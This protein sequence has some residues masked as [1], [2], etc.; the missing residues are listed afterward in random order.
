MRFLLGFVI[1]FA[2]AQVT[3]SSLAGVVDYDL[4]IAETRMAPAGKDVRVLTINGGIPGPTLRF[5]E[6]DIAR[7]V[8]RNSLRHEQT[9]IH[10]HGLL[11]PNAMD[12]VPYLTTPP[13]E[14]GTEMVFEFP[15]KHAGTYW[16]HS[17]TGLQEQSGVYG[18]IVVEPKGGEPIA[19]D[20]DVVVVLSDWTNERPK[21][22]M[23]T[24]MRGSDWYSIEK[25]NAQSILG[26]A[27]AG[28]L[29]DYFAREKAR[30]APMDVSD[31][32]YD[33]FLLN[34]QRRCVQAAKPGDRVRLRVINAAASSYFYLHSAT[35]PLTIVA[36]DGPAVE[37][38]QVDRLLIG[39]AETYDLLLTV[40]PSG[41]WEFRATAQDNTGHA[42]LFIGD[43]AGSENAATAL[44]SPNLYT[45]D[46]ML[47]SALE[48]EDTPLDEIRENPRPSA[49]Y[50][51]LRSSQRT[52]LSGPPR[53]MTL[54]LTG[55]MT[56]YLWSFNGKTLA[57]DSTIPVAK[58]EVL[59]M[60]LINDTMMHHPLHLHGHFFR[61]LNRN[62]D[63]SPLKHTV[64]VPPMGSRTI[65]F[66]ADEEGDW[67]FHCH[68]LYHMDAGMA[69]VFSY[70]A[71]EEPGYQ[72]ALDPKMENP[73]YFMI[74][75]TALSSMTMGMATAMSGRENLS[76]LWDYGYDHGEHHA[77]NEY[78]AVWS[79]YFDP[80][81]STF[82]G[83][84]LTDDEAAEDRFFGGVSYRLPYLVET[85]AAADSEGDF[86]F[87]VARALQLTSRLSAVAE[88]EYDTNTEWDYYGGLS[89]TLTKQISLTTGYHS[90][91][92]YGIG[93]SF[94]L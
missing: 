27:R 36:A 90:H 38:V 60:E 54:R 20:H 51:F 13:I 22:V 40:P 74:D 44:P 79:H 56:R 15:L 11:V 52:T 8:V 91:H 53:E 21:E 28:A 42:S 94:R 78:D 45:M 24:L 66:L 5:R 59:R 61:V 23:R 48:D 2:S 77:E 50:A 35:G 85:E 19:A 37:A 82:L 70:R 31:I 9:S 62:G 10:W 3:P 25:G 46:E 68:L 63:F 72:P 18:S 4:T 81:F 73:W 30:M 76:L 55:D 88:L 6:G 58:G 26:A 64:D 17:H 32:A 34:G 57:E 93:V 47:L 92:G 86:R 14:A 33:A 89:Y 43:P 1:A 16:Y 39:M 71:A 80:N 12:G 67:F 84:R 69:R 65:E 49:P 29:G 83:Y 87:T 7:I 41:L 75:G